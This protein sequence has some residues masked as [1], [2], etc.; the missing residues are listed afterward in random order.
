MLEPTIL[1]FALVALSSA[2]PLHAPVGQCARQCSHESQFVRFSSGNTY[3]YDFRTKTSLSDNQ[4]VSVSATAL[5]SVHNDCEL[6]LQIRDSRFEGV[7]DSQSLAQSLE[8]FP[9]HFGYDDGVVT[10]VCSVAG[11]QQWALDV[12]KAVVSAL[13]MSARSRSPQTVFERDVVGDCETSYSPIASKAWKKTK[14]LNLCRNRATTHVGLFPRAFAPSLYSSVPL[15]S[16]SFECIQSFDGHI[17]DAVTCQESQALRGYASEAV[18]T[19]L[20]L[21]LLKS[22]KGLLPRAVAYPLSSHLKMGNHFQSEDSSQVVRALCQSLET[23]NQSATPDLFSA[24]VHSLRQVSLPELR[25]LALS[26]QSQQFKELLLDASVLSG[27]EGGAQL[28]AQSS[29]QLSLSRQ[30]YLFSLL[31]FTATPSS[32]SAK[33]LVPLLREESVADHVLLGVSGLVHNLKHS[34]QES[35]AEDAIAALATTLKRRKGWTRVP[36]IRALASIGLERSPEVRQQLLSLAIDNK[37]TTSVRVTAIAALSEGMTSGESETLFSL[38]ARRNESNEIRIRSYKAVVMSNPETRLLQRV[39]RVSEAEDEKRDIRQYVRSHQQN[40]R[41]T[42]DPHKRFSTPEPNIRFPKPDDQWFGVSNNFES[43][44]MLDAL[45]FGLS[46]EADVIHGDDRRVPQS[47]TINFTVPAFGR[48]LQVFEVEVRQKGMRALLNNHLSSLR[49]LNPSEALKRLFNDFYDVFSR[50]IRPQDMSLEANLKVD[51]KTLFCYHSDR[52]DPRLLALFRSLIGEKLEHAVGAQPINMRV[53]LPTGSGLPVEVRLNATVVASLKSWIASDFRS[54]SL[55]PTI[56]AKVETALQLSASSHRKTSSFVSTFT[57]APKWRSSHEAR[58]GRLA[59]KVDVQSQTLFRVKSVVRRDGAEKGVF[60]GFGGAKQCFGWTSL[61]VCREIKQNSAFEV[62]L[63]KS[64]QLTALDFEAEYPRDRAF[65]HYSLRLNGADKELQ[66]DAT[67]DRNALKASVRTPWFRHSIETSLVNSQKEQSLNVVLET[68]GRKALSAS[69]G[70]ETQT[71]GQKVDFRPKVVIQWRNKEAV[72][73]LGS[74]SLSRGKKNALQVQLEGN[75]K[76][77]LKGSL[78]REGNK[79]TDIRISTDLTASLANLEFRVQG[80]A[81]RTPKHAET[82]LTIEYRFAQNRKESLKVSAKLQDLSQSQV[83]KVSAFGE[84][85]TTQWPEANVHLAYNLLSRAGQQ[86]ENELTLQWRRRLDSKVHVLA[87]SKLT[88]DTL[89]NT[90]GLEVTPLHLNYELRLNADLKRDSNAEK[91]FNAEIV[92]KDRNGRKDHDLRASVAFKHVSRSPLH[93]TLDAHIRT[94]GRNVSLS[95]ALIER[96]KGEFSGETRV[97]WS[98]KESANF[99]YNYRLNEEKHEMDARL[100][101]MGKAWTHAGHLRMSRPLAL[102]STLSSDDSSLYSIDASLDSD[103][104]S[105]DCQSRGYASKALY[106][107]RDKSR[108]LATIEV[109]SPLAIHKTS[110]EW[111]RDHLSL[112]S[113][114]KNARMANLVAVDATLSRHS[115]S[116]VHLSSAPFEAKVEYDGAK[117]S[118]ALKGDQWEHESRLSFGARETLFSSKSLQKGNPFASFETRLSPKQSTLSLAIPSKKTTIRANHEIKS[119]QRVASLLLDMDQI[120]HKTDFRSGEDSARFETKTDVNR[121]PVLA[122]VYNGNGRGEHA[123]QSSLLSD[124]QLECVTNKDFAEMSLKSKPEV[125]HSLTRVSRED[126][127]YRLHSKTTRASL[128]VNELHAKWTPIEKSLR[129]DSQPLKHETTVNWTPQLTID[130]KTTLSDRFVHLTG[131]HAL[132]MSRLALKTDSLDSEVTRLPDGGSLVIESRDPRFPL[133]HATRVSASPSAWRVE[134]RT[135]RETRPLLDVSSTIGWREPSTVALSIGKDLTFETKA[136][137]F[138]RDKSLELKT[139]N[140]RLFSHVS[141]IDNNDDGFAFKSRT[142]DNSGANIAK[143]DCFLGD[144]SHL[145]LVTPRAQAHFQVANSGAQVELKSNPFHHKTSVQRLDD[146]RW[147]IASQTTRD[148]HSLATLDSELSPSVARFA[149][150]SE[151]RF[152]SQL[153]VNSNDKSLDFALETPRLNHETSLSPR[154]IAS[155]TLDAHSRPLAVL[156][157]DLDTPSLEVEIPQLKA[158]TSLDVNQ[159]KAFLDLET[160]VSQRRHLLASVRAQEG[161][162]LEFQW[163]PE[164]ALAKFNLDLSSHEEREHWSRVWIGDARA[165]YAGNVLTLS[166]RMS[167]ESP[168]SG[169]HALTADFKPKYNSERDSMA[170]HVSHEV[171]EKTMQCRLALSEGLKSKLKASIDASLQN[172][173]LNLHFVSTSPNPQLQIRVS[174]VE[175]HENLWSNKGNLFTEVSLQR[176]DSK[177]LYSVSAK[178]DGQTISGDAK[179]ETPSSGETTLAF[180]LDD[181]SAKVESRDFDLFS[182]YDYREGLD[183]ALDFKS[184]DLSFAPSFGIHSKVNRKEISGFVDK[185]G[186]RVVALSVRQQ[187]DSLTTGLSLEASANSPWTPSLVSRSQL[188]STSKKVSLSSHN[189]LDNKEVLVLA[190]DAN[191]VSSVWTGNARIAHNGLELAKASLESSL[192]G[193]YAVKARSD[194]RWVPLSIA[195]DLKSDKN[196][197]R[198]TAKTCARD[199]CFNANFDFRSREAVIALSHKGDSVE[200]R[201]AI[202]A[203]REG[204]E[205]SVRVDNGHLRDQYLNELWVRVNTDQLGLKQRLFR[206]DNGFDQWMTI[207]LPNQP[208]IE[209]KIAMARDPLL[210][211]GMISRDQREVFRSEVESDSRH[212]TL[213]VWSEKWTKEKKAFLRWTE[214]TFNADLDLS[215]E[216]RH[217]LNIDAQYRKQRNNESVTV[218]IRS[219]DGSVDSVLSFESRDKSLSFVLLGNGRQRVVSLESDGWRSRALFALKRKTFVFDVS[220]DKSVEIKAKEEKSGKSY[221][222]SLKKDENCV[223]ADV[224]HD[225]Q[226]QQTIAVCLDFHSND[227]ILV[228]NVQQKSKKAFEAKLGLK[229]DSKALK[230]SLEWNSKALREALENVI[231]DNEFTQDLNRETKDF[232][233][234]TLND[235]L[236]PIGDSLNDIVVEVVKAMDSRVVRDLF[237]RITDSFEKLFEKFSEMF[238]SIENSFQDFKDWTQR[239]ARKACKRNNPCYRVLYAIDNFGVDALQDVVRDLLVASARRSHQIVLRTSGHVKGWWPSAPQWLKATKEYVFESFIAFFESKFEFRA[240]FERLQTIGDEI[241]RDFEAIDWKSIQKTFSEIFEIIF[242]QN[243]SRVVVW[244]PQEGRVAI[245]I[246]PAVAQPLKAAVESAKRDFESFY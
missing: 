157:A 236:A 70:L 78:V 165:D 212:V 194:N 185:N 184:R 163:D 134:S 84:L 193:E 138:S 57:S 210:W 202:M 198:L 95:D 82:D 231:P 244:Q 166:A 104:A 13:Q 101:S 219:R 154:R 2:G 237:S 223:S 59:L 126:D 215:S 92:G 204:E 232:F 173:G 74:V 178:R 129:F 238:E 9:L 18:D 28:L 211:K 7:D 209:T 97:Q 127:G 218:N 15:M 235:F 103:S 214:S 114:T 228:F 36:V 121:L 76:Q 222:L 112:K 149:V 240:L 66:A 42:Q 48:E 11:D 242:A 86:L 158:K 161:L 137:L 146:Q 20:S 182:R 33:T 60:W 141:R 187:G 113:D 179:I 147:T 191:R 176:S 80:I 35:H 14:A 81:E 98:P 96:S 1:L 190:L 148:G 132:R 16:A 19:R 110:T 172:N 144:K 89:E 71:R 73:L 168:L 108:R 47:L 54:V 64:P 123:L 90:V 142:E 180:S 32:A 102:R 170:L 41:E 140:A 83:T 65:G 17:I 87:V 27:S 24:L 25:R 241:S 40:L 69:L 62:S 128:P 58:D 23:P 85:T 169:P 79:A 8:A 119:G 143:V 53:Q 130:S 131:S 61:R 6:A 38:F 88:N 94:I 118:L 52:S 183:F 55:E 227:K 195:F 145:S 233:D 197:K 21:R 105:F 200:A 136:D 43:S 196:A 91:V 99:K 37:E 106:D 213:S 245:E 31:S 10:D 155:R 221:A 26:C 3:E 181:K 120:N 226:N 192:E 67:V 22:S 174:V 50:D 124:Y 125:I 133:S 239:K 216:G 160:R 188:M 159:R 44:L 177:F 93:L 122:L 220:I 139:R 46:L 5:L 217:A 234:R 117:G 205:S 243:V 164:D 151:K 49:A 203:E 39:L 208:Q 153:K 206:R 201:V 152:K 167:P 56:N 75:Q 156:H 68:N 72:S 12:K 4:F 175:K 224:R 107:S 162:H 186:E 150:S 189:S 111:S 77:F 30:M 51:G 116:S 225:Q 100:E 109:K 229:E 45:G 135:S 63:E 29:A 115:P 199:D 171:K 246:R 230:A 207:A 34:H